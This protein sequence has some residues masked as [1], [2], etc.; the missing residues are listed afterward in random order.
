ME[1]KINTIPTPV[2]QPAAIFDFTGTHVTA[3]LDRDAIKASG[4]KVALYLDDARTPTQVLPGYMPWIVV[5]NFR[6]FASFIMLNGIPDFISFD[7]DLHPEHYAPMQYWN[8]D[9][10]YWA[11]NQKFKHETGLD[12]VK[13]LILWCENHPEL[14]IENTS[15]HSFNK[16]RGHLMRTNINGY[17]Q[18]RGWEPNC[19]EGTHPFKEN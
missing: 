15:I 7:H 10:E 1:D 8:G 2:E 18:H 12:C 19:Y 13:W 4:L 16:V 17:K 3:R 14:K 9:Y 11:A 6:E 5:R